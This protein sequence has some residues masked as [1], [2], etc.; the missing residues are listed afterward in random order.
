MKQYGFYVDTT[1]C[2]GCKTCTVACK[3]KNDSPLDVSFRR[4]YE[5]G[6]GEW[7]EENGTWKQN[8]SGYYVSLSCNHCANPACVKACPTGAMHKRKEDGLVLVDQ[9]RCVG[10]QYCTMACPYGAPQYDSEK[11]HMSKCDGCIDRINQGLKPTCVEAC[12]L[13]A[14]DFAPIEELKSKYSGTAELAPLP[15]ATMTSP[16][17]IIKTNVH[18]RPSGDRSGSI[19]NKREV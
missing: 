19:Q 9:E 14:I 3:D 7:I 6:S 13:R 4:V 2:T 10:C 5:Y 17:I 15:K 18:A 1:R 12:P 8:V 11:K 16:S